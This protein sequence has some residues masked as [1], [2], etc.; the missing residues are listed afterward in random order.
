[1]FHRS[2]LSAVSHAAVDVFPGVVGQAV[3]TEL[4]LHPVFAV[5]EH[6]L[7][8]GIVATFR[9]SFV[10]LSAHL[11]G[12]EI[13]QRLIYIPIVFNRQGEHHGQCPHHPLH[14]H[15]VDILCPAVILQQKHYCCHEHHI[16]H[17]R[18]PIAQH[19]HVAKAS[20]ISHAVGN[21]KIK[22]EHSHHSHQRRE[23]YRSKAAVKPKQD[24]HA[25]K[26]FCHRQGKCPEG[27]ERAERLEVQ[28]GNVVG[29][30]IHRAPRVD[31]FCKPRQHKHRTHQQAHHIHCR[32]N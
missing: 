5:D 25:Q 18:S 21:G 4:A 20:A 12:A 27:L 13:N 16:L 32:R 8:V 28:D 10:E 19:Q 15:A 9:W 6:E 3:E 14:T 7:I 29:K 11:E 24:E 22:R 17:E 26:R 2:H 30:L 31:G 23:H 1:M